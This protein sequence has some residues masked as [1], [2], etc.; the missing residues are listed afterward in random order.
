MAENFGAVAVGQTTAR[1]WADRNNLAGALSN[2]DQ[3]AAPH[4]DD[5]EE[6]EESKTLLRIL[7]DNA[8]AIEAGLYLVFLILFTVY[9]VGVQGNNNDMYAMGE[10]IRRIYGPFASVADTT[11]WFV[12]M[13]GAFINATYPVRYYNDDPIADDDLGHVEGQYKLLG[14][15]NVRQVRVRKD[16]CSVQSRMEVSS[17][18]KHK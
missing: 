18:Q 13:R 8:F 7:E 1:A 16:A 4:L 15:I 12:F 3:A 5:E 10:Q 14:V 6:F 9:A 17:A 2:D 11:S